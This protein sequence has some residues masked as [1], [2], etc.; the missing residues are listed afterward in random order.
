MRKR[1][2]KLKKAVTCMGSRGDS[3]HGDTRI[4][5]QDLSEKPSDS[6]MLL[7]K[8]SIPGV[9]FFENNSLVRIG[10]S[11]GSTVGAQVYQVFPRKLGY[12]LLV[13]SVVTNTRP[14]GQGFG[15][16]S[17]ILTNNVV[18][19]YGAGHTIEHRIR[20]EFLVVA[21]KGMLRPRLKT[22]QVVVDHKVRPS[23]PSSGM[24]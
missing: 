19:M 14:Y 12:H 1:D 22:V 11:I 2:G 15:G 9:G 16:G 23:N 10:D 7:N 18:G 6:M 3:Q 13:E 5:S 24:N 20:F 17:G 21:P 4:I 8:N